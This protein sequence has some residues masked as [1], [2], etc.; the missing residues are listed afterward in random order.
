[1]DKLMLLGALA[2][3]GFVCFGLS[4]VI[5]GE[6]RERTGLWMVVL[7]IPVALGTLWL[8]AAPGGVGAAMPGGSML[9]VL[10]LMPVSLIGLI[11]GLVLVPP[12]VR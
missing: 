6:K 12:G 9:L 8:A 10:V 5:A 1:M 7:T 4:A 11:A 2:F 3:A